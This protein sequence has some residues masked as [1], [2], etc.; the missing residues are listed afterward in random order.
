MVDDMK[1]FVLF[2]VLLIL[3]STT[4]VAQ[5]KRKLKEPDFFIP[6]NDRMHKPEILPK[7]IKTENTI[8][9]TAEKKQTDEI[10]FDEKPEYKKIYD[11]YLIEINN[12]LL[13]KK[14]EENKILDN[15]LSMM[16]GDV[17]EVDEDVLSDIKTQEQYN[18]YMLAKKILDN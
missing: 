16:N 12:F 6:Y 10:V 17:F 3:S 15:D 5:Y 14:F 1:K 18:F 9:K 13:T 4:V 8:N 11:E 2:F 7:L